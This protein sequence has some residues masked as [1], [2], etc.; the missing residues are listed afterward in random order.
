MRLSSTW[1]I[2][3]VLLSRSAVASGAAITVSIAT[4]GDGSLSVG[5]SWQEGVVGQDV[6]DKLREGV[7]GFFG[8]A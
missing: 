4:G 3:R 7:R 1:E 5:F 8:K 6:I 2:G